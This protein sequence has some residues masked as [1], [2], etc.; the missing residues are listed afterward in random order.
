[1]SN[2]VKIVP[3]SGV[4]TM[5]LRSSAAPYAEALHKAFSE[6]QSVAVDFAFIE[7]TQGFV[8]GLLAS[9]LLNEG[10]EGLR[11]MAF[12]N[13]TIDTQAIIRFVVSDRLSQRNAHPSL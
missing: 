6:Y 3:P 4:K 8:D 5:G 9:H 10:K 2:I 13:C 12:H 7:V 11:R 1:M